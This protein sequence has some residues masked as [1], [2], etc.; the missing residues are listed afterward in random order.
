M[1]QLLD[2]GAGTVLAVVAVVVIGFVGTLGLG[3]L[4]GV[5]PALRPLVVTGFSICEASAIDAMD[6]VT[7]SEEEHVA[8]SIALVT[9]YGTLAIACVPL[10]GPPVGLSGEGLGPWAGLSVHEVAQVVAAASPPG[11]AA[12]AAAVV[13]QLRR[14]VLLAPTWPR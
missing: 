2:F 11:A 9:L 6:S 14:A 1:P 8:T 13:V 10:V 4:L 5:P 12:V 3:R 7:R